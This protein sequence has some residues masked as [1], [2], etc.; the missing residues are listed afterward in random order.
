MK[1]FN[2]SEKEKIIDDDG[3][4]NFRYFNPEDVKEFIKELKE[5]PLC[6]CS[7]CKSFECYAPFH[8]KVLLIRMEKLN[9]LAGEKLINDTFSEESE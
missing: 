1:E 9:K 7:K 2:L 6:Y 8:K 5:K 4:I 3:F